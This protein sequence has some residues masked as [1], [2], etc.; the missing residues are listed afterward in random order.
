MKMNNLERHLIV[1]MKTSYHPKAANEL[2][3]E[4][5]APDERLAPYHFNCNDS[6]TI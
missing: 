1:G 6:I 5:V 2:I 3:N 4:E